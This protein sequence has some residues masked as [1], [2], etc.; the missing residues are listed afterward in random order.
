MK[1]VQSFWSK[2]YLKYRNGAEHCP[3]IKH[4]FLSW[5]LSC[6]KAR[7]F[8]REIELVT[9]T[10]GREILIDILKLPYTKVDLRL[11]EI[12]QHD[13]DFYS[14]GKIVAYGMQ[15]E[16]FIHM[17]GDV[18]LWERFPAHIE[19]ASLIGQNYEF[20]FPRYKEMMKVVTARLP[21][22]TGNWATDPTKIWAINM[23][24]A[25]GRD[26]A[27]FQEY[28]RNVLEFVDTHSAVIN[29]LRH[30]DKL[31]LN[32]FFE[33]VYYF[34]L[35]T[36]KKID[37]DVF[38]AEMDS[39]FEILLDFERAQS[40]TKYIHLIG[41]SKTETRYCKIVEQLLAKEFPAF[42]SDVSGKLDELAAVVQRS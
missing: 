10:W 18:F 11:D 32:L 12:N 22:L 40:Q 29:S 13:C 28:S 6:L 15:R 25:G 24:I 14:I 37:I 31:L 8:Y 35:A 30:Y 26:I 7:Q 3:E 9:D 41:S 5:C 27:F 39:S 4:V 16:P 34:Q 20:N 2:P 33:Q 21:L 17:D 42:A 38:F 1:I 23:G 36:S 19:N